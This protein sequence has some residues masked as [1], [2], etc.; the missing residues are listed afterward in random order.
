MLCEFPWARKSNQ[1]FQ[2]ALVPFGNG[3][4][5]W[6]RE[7]NVGD[8]WG[9][10]TI[11]FA[12]TQVWHIRVRL[13]VVAVNGSL[14]KIILDV[15]AQCGEVHVFCLLTCGCKPW[16][17]SSWSWHALTWKLIVVT[18]YREAKFKVGLLNFETP[19]LFF[20]LL[21]F[22]VVHYPRN[23]CRN[24]DFQR[25]VRVSEIGGRNYDNLKFKVV[26]TIL[27]EQEVVIT[28]LRDQNSLI[29]HW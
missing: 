3:R 6:G 20:G 11:V 4:S 19:T 13:N 16:H 9:V 25:S 1:T 12:Q 7:L 17:G 27:V 2:R 14:E 15:Q 23:W 18:Y 8:K 29:K 10:H 22:T 26:L 5:I 24:Y 28:N 21:A